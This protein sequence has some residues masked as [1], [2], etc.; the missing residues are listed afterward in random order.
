MPE[1]LRFEGKVMSATVSRMA[2]RWFV[3]IR[4]EVE[5]P[6][7]RGET[8]ARTVGVD[9]GVKRL[10]TISDGTTVEGP[11]PQ[12]SMRRRLAR[13]NRRLS[14]KAPGSH[15]RAKIAMRVARCHAHV[16]HLRHDA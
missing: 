7:G 16:A 13:L 10:A 8:Q 3:A 5:W 9:L 6:R 11:K 14:R 2:H 4:V 15:H 12:Q 1:A